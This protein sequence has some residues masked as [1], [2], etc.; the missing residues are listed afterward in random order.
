LKDSFGRLCFLKKKEDTS[1]VKSLEFETQTVWDGKDLFGSRKIY[2]PPSFE[3]SL[4][5]LKIMKFF[6]LNLNLRKKIFIFHKFSYLNS[7]GA[8]KIPNGN[9]FSES[10]SQKC[11]KFSAS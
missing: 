2:E 11:P 1:F 8:E 4:N 3:F 9:I 5:I 10:L 7:L 6:N